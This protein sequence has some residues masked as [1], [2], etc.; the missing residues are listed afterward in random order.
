MENKKLL[1]VIVV[2]LLLCCILPFCGGVILFFAAPATLQ[3]LLD[4]AGLDYTITSTTNG[5]PTINTNRIVGSDEQDYK[6]TAFGFSIIIPKTWEV[7]ENTDSVQ[8]TPNVGNGAINFEAF[9]DTSLQT[10][11]TIDKDFCDSFGEGFR[12]GLGAEA[13][14]ADQFQFE[15]FTLNGNTG[16]RSEGSL[17]EG[18]FQ[19]YYVFFNNNNKKIYSIFYTETGGDEKEPLEKALDSFDF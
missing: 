5:N 4:S 9:E 16:C 19:R 14:V 6:N 2:L 12:S 3:N 8:I 18:V 13:D 11:T 17:F 1:I 7:T 10:L 15:L